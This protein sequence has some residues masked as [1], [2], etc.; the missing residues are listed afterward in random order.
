MK[1]LSIVILA[2]TTTTF[3]ATEDT[4]QETYT[5]LNFTNPYQ[6]P[7]KVVWETK[8]EAKERVELPAIPTPTSKPANTSDKVS[9][10]KFVPGSG[11]GWADYTA[12]VLGEPFTGPPG[13]FGCG[14]FDPANMPNIRLGQNEVP[15]GFCDNLDTFN[16]DRYDARPMDLPYDKFWCDLLPDAVETYTTLM[17]THRSPKKLVLWRVDPQP[18]HYMNCDY[19]AY[20]PNLRSG[21]PFNVC[22]THD[23]WVNTSTCMLQNRPTGTAT[24]EWDATGTSR[25][26]GSLVF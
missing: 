20:V 22:D 10:A 14:Y 19:P 26:G 17:Y 5:V 24:W 21:I 11:W 12:N 25:I 16:P 18:I 4:D 7:V 6:K 8:A 2:L 23:V 9:N 15:P 13:I 1:L 3:A